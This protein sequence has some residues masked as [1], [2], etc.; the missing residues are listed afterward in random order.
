LRT[1]EVATFAKVGE[2]FVPIGQF[3]GPIDD[4]EH[5]EGAIELYIE[6]QMVSSM[7]YWDDVNY[8]WD[9]LVQGVEKLARGEEWSTNWPDQPIR[10]KFQ[11]L[12]TNDLVRVERTGTSDPDIR[13][14]VEKVDLMKALLSGASEFFGVYGRL[15]DADWAAEV[16]RAIDD[17]QTSLDQPD[18]DAPRLAP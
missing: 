11:P 3:Q 12:P 10:L 5:F 2:R 7:P 15:G 4:P 16:Q 18:L 17:L 8:L 14:F 13:V 9:F 6:G 1:I